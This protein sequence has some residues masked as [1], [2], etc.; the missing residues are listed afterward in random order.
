MLDRRRIYFQVTVYFRSIV[1]RTLQ[2]LVG[3]LRFSV[4]I[5]FFFGSHHS[6]VRFIEEL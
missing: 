1:I 4:A 2:I 5:I 3:L 6:E